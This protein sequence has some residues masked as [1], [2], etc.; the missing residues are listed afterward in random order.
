MK[1]PREFVT[2]CAIRDGKLKI[3]NLEHLNAGLAALGEGDYVLR[4]E[5]P[6]ATRSDR[7]NRLYWAGYVRPFAEHTGYTPEEMHEY[8]KL[9]FLSERARRL[10]LADG[11]GEVLD[12]ATIAALTTKTLTEQ[13]FK[14]Y[15]RNIEALAL[16]MDIAVGSHQVE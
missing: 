15:L 11:K 1:T 3:R 12:D 7:L 9:R 16:S 14:D 13:E 10:V 4:I 6:R 2:T 8:F 5:L